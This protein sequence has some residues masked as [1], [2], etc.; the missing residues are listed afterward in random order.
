[1]IE[2]HVR[3]LLRMNR[4]DALAT[5]IR[6]KVGNH[7]DGGTVALQAAESRLGRRLPPSLR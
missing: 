7:T 2:S 3:E 5:V 4:S 6:D 1:M